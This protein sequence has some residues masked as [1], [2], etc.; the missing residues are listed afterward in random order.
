MR[1]TLKQSKALLDLDSIKFDG[2]NFTNKRICR[3]FKNR[4]LRINI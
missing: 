4:T 1:R 2:D 3:S